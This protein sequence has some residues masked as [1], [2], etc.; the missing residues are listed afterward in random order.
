MGTNFHHHHQLSSS[1]LTFI[2]IF[3]FIFFIIGN[4]T[5][6][7]R[8]LVANSLILSKIYSFSTACNFSKD[9]FSN[10]QKMLDDFTHKK[11]ISA[12]KRKYLPLRYAGLYIPNVYLKH[13][14]LR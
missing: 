1:S 5:L 10:L 2:Y 9:D 11:K 13:L 7:G 3:I 4:I 12:G 6:Q 8:K 14:T